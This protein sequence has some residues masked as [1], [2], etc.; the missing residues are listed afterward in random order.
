MAIDAPRRI[1]LPGGWSLPPLG[2]AQLLSMLVVAIALWAAGALWIGLQSA[3]HWAGTLQPTIH[4][5][6][7]QSHAK[8]RQPLINALKKIPQI[9][10]IHQVSQQETRHW[11]HSWLGNNS[12]QNNHLINQ[13]PITLQTE[14]HGSDPFLLDDIKDTAQRFHASINPDEL[15]LL[16]ARKHLTQIRNL[17]IGCALL[18]MV[19]LALIITNTL[20]LSLLAREDEL[21]LMR[22]MGAHEWF[23]RLPFILE[24]MLIGSGAGIVALL[25]Q[26]PLI[27]ALQAIGITTDGFSTL[28]FPLL[29]GGII[30]GT[31]GAIL[32]QPRRT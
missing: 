27:W 29:V 23:I 28:I 2:R 10:T 1:R 12:K 26:L 5:Y 16:T 22:L 19:G 31:I 25:L 21:E 3:I 17:L 24:G 14:I 8:Q 4:F 30:M 13:L 6:L 15:R 7:P 9:D 18:L 32:A 11:L 20:E